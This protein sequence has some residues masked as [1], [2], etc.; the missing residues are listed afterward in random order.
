V[1]YSQV[2]HGSSFGTLIG[3]SKYRRTM[4][5]TDAKL[6]HWLRALRQ[7]STCALKSA[8]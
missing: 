8:P 7:C 2:A 5:T 3:Q 6:S 1:V 4:T